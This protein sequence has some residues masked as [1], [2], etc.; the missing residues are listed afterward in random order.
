MLLG[1]VK[2]GRVNATV[3][4]CSECTYIIVTAAL[5]VTCFLVCG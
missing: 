4:H 1:C 3:K 2:F 5:L